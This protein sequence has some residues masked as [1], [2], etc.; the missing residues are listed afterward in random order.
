MPNPRKRK[1]GKTPN[2]PITLATR[3]AIALRY[4]CGGDPKDIGLAHGVNAT[5]EVLKS[6]WFVVDAIHAAES[7]DIKFPTSHDEQRRIAEGFRRKSRI[8]LSNCVGAI[9]G[10]LVWIHK[11]SLK[12]I[13]ENIKFGPK[14]FFCRRKKKYGVNLMGTCDHRGYFLDVEIRHPGATSD[15]YAFLN[16]NLRSKLERPGFLAPGLCLYGDNAYVN[17]HYMIVPFKGVVDAVKDA[18]NFFQSSIRINIECAFGMLVHRWGILRKQMPM[19]I[20][21]QKATSLTL[22]LCKLHNFCIEERDSIERPIARDVV[23]IAN[24]GGMAL[25]RMDNNDETWN[26]NLHED[27]IDNLMDGGEHFDDVYRV[28]RRRM[29]RRMHLPYMSMLQMVADGGY[30]RPEVGNNDYN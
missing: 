12:D 20:T 23:Y 1:R 6:V 15:F 4:F 27:R 30:T 21:V 8:G 24:G 14:K 25:P 9:D 3:L 5:N 26:Y 29:E 28:D 22:C 19:N 17:S 11:P 7:M 13:I 18:F 10:L 2:G 16:S